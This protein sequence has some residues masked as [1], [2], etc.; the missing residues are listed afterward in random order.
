M[1]TVGA[2]TEAEL[3]HLGYFPSG[4]YFPPSPTNLATIFP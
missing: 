4:L 1:I 2:G 3:T